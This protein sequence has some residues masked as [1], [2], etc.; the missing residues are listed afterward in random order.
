[1]KIDD[2]GRVSVT[3]LEAFT[4]LY[5]SKIHDLQGVF[6]DDTDTI[7]QYN[8]ACDVNADR[9]PRLDTLADIMV[10]QQEFDQKNQAQWFMPDSYQKFPLVE[11]LYSQ[12]TTD[13]QHTRVNEE[14]ALFVQ[15][16]MYDLLIYLKYLVDTMREHRIVWG[17]GR[18]SSVA[19]YVLY[20]LKV[21]RVDSLHYNLD[22]AEFLR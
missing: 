17:V 19:S 3:E 1:M 21:H 4:A 2:Y 5:H 6:V 22:I 18:G 9:M 8:Q 14:L 16:G 15:Y 7:N 20:L 11:W 10:S 13:E 12:C